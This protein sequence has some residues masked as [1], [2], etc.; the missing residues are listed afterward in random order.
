MSTKTLTD[1][2]K[3]VGFIGIGKLGM[4]CAEAVSDK[5]FH[6]TG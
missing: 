5:G 4:P 2:I 6:V 3:T 1:F